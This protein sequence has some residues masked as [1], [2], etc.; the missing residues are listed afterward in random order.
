MCEYYVVVIFKVVLEVLCTIR[1]DEWVDEINGEIEKSSVVR[2]EL[3]DISLILA[4]TS[5]E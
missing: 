1:I 2:K 3:V 5:V 4:R